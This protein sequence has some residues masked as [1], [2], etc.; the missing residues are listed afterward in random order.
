M[1]LTLRYKEMDWQTSLVLAVILTVGLSGMHEAYLVHAVL[2]A[3]NLALYVIKDKSIVSLPV[4]VREV[5]LVSAL[6]A[7]W[8]PAWWLF[9]VLLLG[10]I[11]FLLFDF[12]LVTRALLLMPWNRDVKLQ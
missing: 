1:K 6:I 10:L 12:C 5:Y 9:I 3:L 8:P 7:L 11:I 2:S 4:Q